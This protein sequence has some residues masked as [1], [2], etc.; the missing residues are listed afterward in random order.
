[1]RRRA[2]RVAMRRI[3]WTDQRMR[4]GW[5]GRAGAAF[6]EVSIGSRDGVLS[7]SWQTPASPGTYG[8]ANRAR[9][10]FRFGPD[11]FGLGGLEAVLDG[12]AAPLDHGQP[13]DGS[14]GRAPGGEVGA[15]SIGDAAPDQ[16]AAG[17]Q[18]GVRAPVFVCIE[19]G[20]FEIRPVV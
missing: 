1:M 12:P 11:Q 2:M 20:Q 4:L 16:Q 10:G 5:P 3:S 18:A 19:I 6:S 8:D 7:P 14:A 15:F 17:P 13:L 9:N